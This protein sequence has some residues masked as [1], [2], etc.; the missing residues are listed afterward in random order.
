M[1]SAPNGR[2][3]EIL[4]E[5][6]GPLSL[7]TAKAVKLDFCACWRWFVEIGWSLRDTKKVK[8]LRPDFLVR[9]KPRESAHTFMDSK[10]LRRKGRLEAYRWLTKPPGAAGPF[11][12]QFFGTEVAQF[13]PALLVAPTWIPQT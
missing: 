2:N 5:V 6:V 3:N 8:I 9:T 12:Y 7:S 11:F 13:T 10:P 1:L 4:R